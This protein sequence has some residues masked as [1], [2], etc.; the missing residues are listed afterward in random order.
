MNIRKPLS[1]LAFAAFV[2]PLSAH[3]D[4]P[5]GEYFDLFTT[6]SAETPAIASDR[7]EH[8]NYVEFSVS[9]LVGDKEE[10]RTVVSRDDV[11]RELA[12]SPM[13]HIEA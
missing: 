13:P 11:A 12:A 3:A 7:A 1:V 5:S 9:D 10:A 4:A 2:A 8:R 6:P